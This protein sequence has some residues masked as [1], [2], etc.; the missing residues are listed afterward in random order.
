LTKIQKRHILPS[1]YSNCSSSDSDADSSGTDP[2]VDTDDTC[3]DS[4]DDGYADGT[5]VQ[6]ARMRNRWERYVNRELQM[7][8]NADD[9]SMKDI[10]ESS[11]K[12]TKCPPAR[13]GLT[14]KPL[15]ELQAKGNSHRFFAGLSRYGEARMDGEAIP[16]KPEK[17]DHYI[18][19]KVTSTKGTVKFHRKEPITRGSLSS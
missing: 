2:D 19:C 7:K 13:S 10:A 4:E 1:Q 8:E 6:I 9:A 3:S 17:D 11:I 18:F 12:R 15:F 16:L 5:K 14:Q